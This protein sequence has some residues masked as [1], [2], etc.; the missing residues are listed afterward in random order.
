MIDGPSG[1]ELE[2]VLYR[3]LQQHGIIDSLKLHLRASLLRDLRS[4]GAG[5][6][7]QAK[8]PL[9]QKAAEA[10]ISNF[11][12]SMNYG[13]TLSVFAPECGEPSAASFSD[14]EILSIFHIFPNTELFRALNNPEVDEAA[15]PITTLARPPGS[16]DLLPHTEHQPPPLLLRIATAL[17]TL[18]R[19]EEATTHR[20]VQTDPQLN[21]L[22][23]KLRQVG[24]HY[25]GRAA[26][27]E[28]LPLKQVC[29]PHTRPPS[30]LA[31]DVVRTL[32]P[33][34][35]LAFLPHPLT[36]RTVPLLVSSPSQI[37][38]RMMQY[39][40]ECDR[41]VRVEIESEAARIR[42]TEVARVRA[43]ESAKCREEIAQARESLEKSHASRIAELRAHE[44]ELID[45]MAIRDKEVEL[46]KYQGRQQWLQQMEALR[47]READ[48]TRQAEARQHDL[49]A[50][51]ERLREREQTIGDR[52]AEVDR[53]RAE[54]RQR[55]EAAMADLRTG[56]E[57]SRLDAATGIDKE[58]VAIEAARAEAAAAKERQGALQGQL[59]AAEE[60]LVQCR[61]DLA[62]ARGRE[63]AASAQ[64]ARLAQLQRGIPTALAAD[65]S[66]SE[67]L[68]RSRTELLEAQARANALKAEAESLRAELQTQRAAAQA[69]RE[70]RERT[71]T[72]C[73]Q[74]VD[75]M[76]AALDQERTRQ[77]AG[78]S[79]TLEQL[80]A[81]QQREVDELR[82]GRDQAERD[83]EAKAK[84]LAEERARA[85][86][87][88]AQVAAAQAE[89]GALRA[90][91]EELA[92]LLAH[93]HHA[94][95]LKLSDSMPPEARGSSSSSGG[96]D[97]THRLIEAALA[98]VAQERRVVAPPPSPSAAAAPAPAPAAVPPPPPPRRLGGAPFV[99][100]LGLGLRSQPL[101]LRTSAPGS[102]GAGA[103]SRRLYM[104]QPA[105]PS[106]IEDSPRG[107]PVPGPLPVASWS[108]ESA[109]PIR[110]AVAS[111]PA[112]APPALLR[113]SSAGRRTRWMLGHDEEEDENERAAIAREQ[114]DDSD[115]PPP[116][117]FGAT[118][119]LLYFLPVWHILYFL[120]VWR[121]RTLIAPSLFRPRGGAVWGQVEQGSPLG[122]LVGAASA[123]V[124]LEITRAASQLDGLAHREQDLRA[125]RS[126][127]V[128]RLARSREE[129]LARS[130]SAVSGST[131]SAA[132]A[133]ALAAPRIPSEI[134][135]TAS[136]PG[137]L[138]GA[139]RR[140]S[141]IRAL[142]E[143]A[144]AWSP[145]SALAGHG[146]PPAAFGGLDGSV[147]TAIHSPLRGAA[148]LPPLPHGLQLARASV[149]S[150]ASGSGSGS[151]S[152]AGTGSRSASSGGTGPTG[153]GSGGSGRQTPPLPPLAASASPALPPPACRLGEGIDLIPTSTRP[154]AAAAAG[155]SV[156]LPLLPLEP[157][158]SAST[159]VPAPRARGDVPD[160]G[161][162]ES[163][164]VTPPSP[165]G[166]PRRHGSPPPPPASPLMPPAPAP[167]PPPRSPPAS[168]AARPAPE[169]DLSDEGAP[170][171]A[172]PPSPA[173]PASRRQ[174]RAAP[175][176]P[177]EADR[178]DGRRP[179]GMAALETMP[180]ELPPMPMELPPMQPVPGAP[181]ARQPPAAAAAKTPS[182]N[183]DRPE[184]KKEL[185]FEERRRQQE[186]L[187]R[188][189]RARVAN[190]RERCKRREEE[191]EQQRLLREQARA[192]A[193]QPA[194]SPAQQPPRS[195]GPATP[196]EAAP[197][198]SLELSP[199]VVAQSRPAHPEGAP[200]AT[201]PSTPKRQY[202]RDKNGMPTSWDD[203][204]RSPPLTSASLLQLGA[205]IPQGQFAFDRTQML[206][207]G[208][209]MPSPPRP[210]PEPPREGH[211]GGDPESTWLVEMHGPEGM[212][213]H[214]AFEDNEII[215][216]RPTPHNPDYD[217][218]TQEFR[219]RERA[220]AAAAA[221]APGE[222]AEE[223]P[224][225]PSSAESH[226]A[227]S[228]PAPA[229]ATATAASSTAPEPPAKPP[230]RLPTPF[231]S[232]PA[233][234]PAATPPPAPAAAPS[235]PTPA[236]TPAPAVV[237]ALAPAPTM[238]APPSSFSSS[239]SSSAPATASA[240]PSRRPNNVAVQESPQPPA[241]SPA[242][243]ALALAPAPPPTAPG[244]A[245]PAPAKPEEEEEGG[246]MAM[247]RAIL[248]GAA[249]AAPAAEPALSVPPP[250]PAQ[251]A[252]GAGG[253]LDDEIEVGPKT[254]NAA[255]ASPRPTH[256]R[257]MPAPI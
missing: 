224:P 139:L 97:Q 140:L 110:C 152:G 240:P 60:Q 89:V 211:P 101:P 253:G 113:S 41:R 115:L 76:R 210:A 201:T 63:E 241:A 54:M 160:G 47:T 234:T 31:I 9:A 229:A 154:P 130:I 69:E 35:A 171:P 233:P 161:L 14:T 143:Q 21:E 146:G 16:T 133:G 85:V 180:M 48:I 231:A 226:P 74:Q 237:P 103:P 112:P 165:A 118:S 27:E 79:A 178:S 198:G 242:V 122:P 181:A 207:D 137:G 239:S 254:D 238:P 173:Q 186:E 64:A 117:P 59:R 72:D 168:P 10:L 174:P 246:V 230:L 75:A 83:R 32:S 247:Y 50:L 40:R 188:Q 127:L 49:D 124:D 22:E 53:L 6:L 20:G 147:A 256:A 33:A 86:G 142:L 221:A 153:S 84:T 121:T 227:S 252:V 145:L 251:L 123:Q 70:S 126:E 3:K 163:I 108:P 216:D 36:G 91:Q 51:A 116:P 184:A 158:P 220:R 162:V 19:R 155:A 235:Q 93:T 189:E 248:G 56:L 71:I 193:R 228:A 17:T 87:L 77:D 148:P 257:S 80:R 209:Q 182:P 199:S 243:V 204:D 255:F 37:E 30:G 62:A 170:R 57:R 11:L 144:A 136:A 169:D 179:R 18:A 157:S 166:G 190:I 23:Q 42:E 236:A 25:L 100:L 68:L 225:T 4:R 206:G 200:A 196:A 8:K 223:A 109:S 52:L 197:N 172:T 55:G 104:S 120:P 249:A 128:R 66:A 65:P 218:S 96:G 39:Q 135:L 46:E 105:P 67:A 43:E 222:A 73:R 114:E 151:G 176:M 94:L 141:P 138:D 98:Q 106:P 15:P 244:P 134:P 119:G 82:H 213:S 132:P 245:A 78:M 164:P 183:P 175:P 250:A 45:R 107:Y 1:K 90:R 131:L 159:G 156:A 95:L 13:Y 29:R 205:D 24:E 5:R 217:L 7:D 28:T 187:L 219:A 99:P 44:R 208:R 150:A 177:G 195:P 102:L 149:G 215:G 191:E 214:F 58:R 203:T 88:E 232:T 185:S 167:S 61:A 212:P 125:K 192:A 34:R 194:R 202:P 129:V 26:I 81:Q 38:E 2:A 111:P 92:E 12:A